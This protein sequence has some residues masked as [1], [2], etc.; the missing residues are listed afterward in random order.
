[1]SIILC[2]LVSGISGAPLLRL[3]SVHYEHVLEPVV[4][5]TRLLIAM[6]VGHRYVVPVMTPHW[7]VLI[8]LYMHVYHDFLRGILS[9][10]GSDL[11]ASV[12]SNT[13]RNQTQLYGALSKCHV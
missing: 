11:S 8:G 13:H 7:T 1:M 3:I 9:L 12:A 2:S 10:I 5:L 6:D 4:N